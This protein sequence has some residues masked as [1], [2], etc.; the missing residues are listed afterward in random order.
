MLTELWLKLSLIWK[1]PL[2][3][4]Y[5]LRD[6][7]YGAQLAEQKE[8][9]FTASATLAPFILRTEPDTAVDI[10]GHLKQFTLYITDET[11]IDLCI[12]ASWTNF[13]IDSSR[14]DSPIESCQEW[15]TAVSSARHLIESGHAL[16]PFGWWGLE[17]LGQTTFLIDLYLE[18]GG[19][20]NSPAPDGEHPLLFA[21][22]LIFDSDIEDDVEGSQAQDIGELD[23][24]YTEAE[25]NYSN[26][27]SDRDLCVKLL[28]SLISAGSD[29]YHIFLQ[30]CDHCHRC[31]AMTLTDMAFELVIDDIW[32]EAL[33]KCGLD[34]SAV[35][36]ESDRRL[37]KHRKLHGASRTGVDVNTAI[38]E[39]ETSG[40]RRRNISRV[41]EILEA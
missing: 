39:P 11:V 17:R 30:S 31:V 25:D 1:L 15:H 10:L 7:G 16:R 29:V 21:L 6:S 22:R 33:E 8:I 3:C 34:S 5:L 4:Q 26:C 2:I 19:D 40:L 12:A 28:V 32:A 41:E 24:D 23:D 36:E 9:I 13:C 37:A 38:G 18:T 14:M 35:L 27:V 20:P